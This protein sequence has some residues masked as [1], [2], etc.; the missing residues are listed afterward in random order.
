MKIL[1]VEENPKMRQLIRRIVDDF[2]PEV[3]EC[4]D[5]AGA[6]SAYTRYLPDCVLMDIDLP[7]LDGLEAT[8]QIIVDFPDAQILMVT[9]YD[10]ARLRAAAV[11][12]G[13]CGYI[14]KENLLEVR[15]WLGAL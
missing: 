2:S 9:N 12:A 6:L 7:H 1:I 15:Q 13:A 4:V 5:G 10:D 8:R 3:Y 11:E 14:L